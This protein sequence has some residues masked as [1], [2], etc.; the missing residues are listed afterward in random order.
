[1][2]VMRAAWEREET[3]GDVLHLEV[4]QPST[5]APAA[6]RAAAAAALDED[7]LGYTNAVG[8]D[9]L[10][11]RIARHHS[12]E[13]GVDVDTDE[14]VVTA[15]ASAGFVLALL[16]AFDVGD[17]I[18]MTFPGYAAYRNIIGALGLEVV[19]IRVDEA[20]RF[21][22]TPSRLDAAGE[23][24]GLVVASPSNPTG[25]ALTADELTA[26]TDWC[27]RTATRLVSDEIYHGITDDGR[28]LPTARATSD[29][30]VVVQSF[31]KYWS[32][33][34]WRLGW[35]LVPTELRTPVERL[36]QNLYISPTTLSQVAAVAAF[37][38]HDE[39]DRNVARYAT[40]RA[41]LLDALHDGGLSGVAPADGAFYLWVDV[42]SLTDDASALCRTWLDELGVAVTP[43]V[44]FDPVEGHRW[45]RMSVSE[46]TE[47][48]GEAARRLAGWLRRR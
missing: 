45:V 23:L 43:G 7:R 16:A 27:E 12:D 29:S 38:C 11:T 41:L 30:A 42:S 28:T 40:N 4:G 33:T 10:R 39:L 24:D 22:P 1:M 31:S 47:D 20:C 15:G 25:T 48:V 35:L 26:V 34:G 6:V 37:D 2:E 18:G 9:L 32:M 21:V 36:A 3:H 46:S 44:D 17:R 13:Y 14:V 19:G 8:L 5:S